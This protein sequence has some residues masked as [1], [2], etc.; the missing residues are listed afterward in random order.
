MI[1][2]VVRDGND[3]RLRDGAPVRSKGIA[4]EKGVDEHRGS[5]LSKHEISVSIPSD[6]QRHRLSPWLKVGG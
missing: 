2:V 6:F 5:V 4:L 3:I 1:A